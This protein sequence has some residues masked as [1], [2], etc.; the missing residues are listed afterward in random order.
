[1]VLQH[2]VE[3]RN[4][5]IQLQK[6]NI[7]LQEFGFITKVNKKGI[8]ICLKCTNSQLRKESKITKLSTDRVKI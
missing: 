6:M 7:Y 3:L 1:M 8:K 5:L 4:V 2:E